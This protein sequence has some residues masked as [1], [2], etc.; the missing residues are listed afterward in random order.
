MTR[1]VYLCGPITG[2]KPESA[3]N[4][5]RRAGE[6]LAPGIQ[7]IDPTR[8][9]PD[10]SDAPDDRSAEVQLRRLQHGR[11]TVARDRADVTRCDVLLANFLGAQRISIGSV[12]E[13]FWAD[14][15]RKPIVIVREH[16]NVHDHD[17]LNAMACLVC[18]ELE[19]A[20][21][22]VNTLLADE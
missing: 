20:I 17:M 9:S 16:G 13:I 11:V 5:R 10:F 12:G 21:E 2:Q 19:A 7:I 3:R 22:R 14:S 1:L 18:S 6:L 4:W 8:D 15:F